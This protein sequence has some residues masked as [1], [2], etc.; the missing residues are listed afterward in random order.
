MSIFSLNG[1][2]YN[3]IFNHLDFNSIKHFSVT[4]KQAQHVVQQWIP[5]KE[6]E[7]LRANHIA[8]E[9]QIS[10]PYIIPLVP[11]SESSA[12]LAE[13]YK[14]EQL[15]VDQKRMMSRLLYLHDK[16]LSSHHIDLKNFFNDRSS[17]SLEI[18]QLHLFSKTKHNRDYAY[19]YLTDYFLT[20]NSKLNTD[21]SLCWT[22]YCTKFRLTANSKLGDAVDQF[23]RFA[24]HATLKSLKIDLGVCIAECVHH[25]PNILHCAKHLKGFIEYAHNYTPYLRPFIRDQFLKLFIHLCVKKKKKAIREVGLSLFFTLFRYS[26]HTQRIHLID[27]LNNQ[28]PLKKKNSSRLKRSSFISRQNQSLFLKLQKRFPDFFYP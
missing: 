28:L 6:Q 26:N 25:H 19:K 16:H 12:F 23:Y 7:I 13:C 18:L 5:I 22:L 15:I 10:Y 2:V 3:H 11:L 14:Y 20:L 21:Q 17:H 27:F 4:S 24:K 1:D 9:F 8:R